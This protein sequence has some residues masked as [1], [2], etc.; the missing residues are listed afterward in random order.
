VAAPVRLKLEMLFGASFKIIYISPLQK[1]IFERFYAGTNSLV[2][3]PPVMFEG[4]EPSCNRGSDS[5]SFYRESDPHSAIAAVDYFRKNIGE[6]RLNMYGV[7]DSNGVPSDLIATDIVLH[8]PVARREVPE[9]FR[10]HRNLLHIPNYIDSFCLK[11]LE[12]ELCGVAVHTIRE[13]I[14][15]YSFALSAENLRD[16]MQQRSLGR[17]YDVLVHADLSI[18]EG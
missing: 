16:Y 11:V 13:R 6:G 1:E 12:A 18:R 9:V 10:G 17:I 5:L 2:I 3:P 15:R 8:P 4:F 14:G 7:R